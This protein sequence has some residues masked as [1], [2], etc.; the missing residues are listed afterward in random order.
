MLGLNRAGVTIQP[1][2]L[3]STYAKA[4]PE[5]NFLRRHC[6]KKFTASS[7]LCKK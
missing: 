3:N 2:F 5:K 4:I 1:L 7:Y 6:S